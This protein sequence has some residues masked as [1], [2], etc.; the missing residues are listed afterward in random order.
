MKTTSSDLHTVVDELNIIAAEHPEVE[1]GIR[2]QV[3]VLEVMAKST[4]ISIKSDVD[5]DE[6][7]KVLL[8][9]IGGV[10]IVVASI[11]REGGVQLIST[12]SVSGEDI[13]RC[14]SSI[15]TAS[16]NMIH[17]VMEENPMVGLRYLMEQKGGL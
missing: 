2:E 10:G 7:G 12:S 4:I 11:P 3:R 6:L 14:I 9:E 16:K 15:I 13:M 5:Y 8:E 1:D 17:K